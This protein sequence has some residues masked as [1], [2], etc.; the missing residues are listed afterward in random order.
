MVI[1]GYPK[2]LEA[3][4]CEAQLEHYVG[5]WI[6]QVTGE[7]FILSDR[8]GDLINYVLTGRERLRHVRTLTFVS[9][10]IFGAAVSI[11]WAK[12]LGWDG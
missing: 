9:L 10:D 2:P 6:R 4:D 12:S 3:R 7:D 8:F 5:I 1:K 11:V